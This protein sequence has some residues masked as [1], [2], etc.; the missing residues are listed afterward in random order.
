MPAPLPRYA[1]YRRLLRASLAAGALV[2]LALAAALLVAPD[3]LLGLFAL[4]MPGADFYLVLLAVLAAMAGAFYLLAVYD[5]I[6]YGGNIAVAILG[7]G[8]A[9]VALLYTA[10][11][12]GDALTGLYPLAAVELVFAAAHA[13]CWLPIRQ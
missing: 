4:P 13:A 11:A 3:K 10:A 6:A 2:D 9:G 12:G 5:P 7:R 8:T 1:L